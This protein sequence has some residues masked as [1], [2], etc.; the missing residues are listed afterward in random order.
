MFSDHTNLIITKLA[1]L[2]TI[3]LS[4]K[5]YFDPKYRTKSLRIEETELVLNPN[6]EK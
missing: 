6:S 1:I 3:D 2:I 5:T 4:E